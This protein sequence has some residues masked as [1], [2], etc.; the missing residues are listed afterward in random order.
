LPAAGE[1]RGAGVS[2][3]DWRKAMHA[4]AGRYAWAGGAAGRR[5]AAR[6][7]TDPSPRPSPLRGEGEVSRDAAA[8]AG[9]ITRR[10][11]ARHLLVLLAVGAYP[12]GPTPC[13][14]C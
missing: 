7:V 2:A 14:P 6:P 13:F 9:W 5:A 10:V 8:W 4:G 12:R 3:A 11:R 1:S